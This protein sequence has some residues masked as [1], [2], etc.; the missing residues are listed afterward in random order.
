M[1]DGYGESVY[2]APIVLKD[3]PFAGWTTWGEGGDPFET[4]LGPF[5]F[6]ETDTEHME[7]AFLPDK[8]HLNGGGALHGGALMSFADFALFAL[9]HHHLKGG[10]NAVTL[11]FNSEF[12]GAGDLSGRVEAVGE[13]VRATNSVIFVQAKLVQS[14]RT[15]LAFS[16]TLKKLKPR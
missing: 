7:V 1:A 10:V 4:L 11:T 5:C 2:G 12:V 9:A 16:G 8:R 15:L 14:G 6:R 13:V 3:G